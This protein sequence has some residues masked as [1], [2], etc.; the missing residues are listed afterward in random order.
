MSWT[1]ACRASVRVRIAIAA[2]VFGEAMP[3][4]ADPAPNNTTWTGDSGSSGVGSWGVAGNWLTD[5]TTNVVPDA[6]LN[7]ILPGGP[8]NQTISL[9]SGAKAKSLFPQADGYTIQNG[10][11]TLADNLWINE[12]SG[13]TSFR[14]SSN[15]SNGAVSV[16]TPR[17][18]IGAGAASVRNDI[19]L[20]TLTGG[21]A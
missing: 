19:S 21:A 10:D 2:L 7:A 13:T 3:V 14:L 17:V 8:T 9:G 6:T 20:Q 1:R 11:L 16:I 18:T 5:V 15:G 4:Q 12:T